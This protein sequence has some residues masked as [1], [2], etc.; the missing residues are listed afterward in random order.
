MDLPY[1]LFDYISMDRDMLH[2]QQYIWQFKC[3]PTFSIL[4]NESHES[5]KNYDIITAKNYTKT[6]CLNSGEF[7]LMKIYGIHLGTISQEIPKLLF[8]AVF[9]KIVPLELLP[10]FPGDNELNSPQFLYRCYN[11][12]VRL[13]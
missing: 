9:L 10:Q 11:V 5:S 8:C 3:I 1:H 12:A 7:S 6:I 4:A 2:T 13:V